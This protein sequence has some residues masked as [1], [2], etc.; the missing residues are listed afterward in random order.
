MK[1]FKVDAVN[2]R[3]D[4]ISAAAET[5]RKGGV[6]VFPTRNLYGLAADAGNRE[7]LLKIFRIKQ[8]SPENPLLVL[9]PDRS[10]L[11]SLVR[12]I[13]KSAA[14]LMDAFWPGRLTIV[15]EA[16]DSV[17]PELTGGSGKIGIRL[18]GH[19][20]AAALVRATG[21]PVTGTSANLSGNPGCSSISD[22]DG[23]VADRVDAILDAGSLEPGSGST[24]VD[25]TGEKLR[26]IRV[27]AVSEA[28]IRRV[29]S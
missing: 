6:V 7:A 17:P 4:R 21:F 24:V 23:A 29:L 9:I 14:R 5:I 22:L 1:R 3:P 26:I 18:P 2:P 28:D 8:R 25:P 15:F 12:N 20:V 13:P 10:G 11:I 16:R 27:G 19:P